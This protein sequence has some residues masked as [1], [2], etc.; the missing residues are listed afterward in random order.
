MVPS[1]I[2]KKYIYWRKFHFYPC[3]F[4]QWATFIYGFFHCLKPVSWMHINIS[5]LTN[6]IFY[7]LFSATW[8]FAVNTVP[9]LCL[10]LWLKYATLWTYHSLLNHSPTD[11]HWDCCQC[12]AITNSAA[13]NSFQIHLTFLPVHHWDGFWKVGSLGEWLNAYAVFLKSSCNFL[14][15][16]VSRG[17]HMFSILECLVYCPSFTP[18]W[19]NLYIITGVHTVTEGVFLEICSCF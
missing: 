16:E 5:V 3:H 8:L 19:N 10:F 4:P 12:F 7:A 11:D 14:K 9:S 18:I 15:L 13:V 17:K 2:Y 1:Q 6:S